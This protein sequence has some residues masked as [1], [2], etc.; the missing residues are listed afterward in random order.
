MTLPR[1]ALAAV[2]WAV[3]PVLAYAQGEP[4]LP[5]PG[6]AASLGWGLLNMGG[7]GVFA[8]VVWQE[9][10]SMRLQAAADRQAYLE[11]VRGFA[12]AAR[13]NGEALAVLRDRLERRG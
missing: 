1:V 4:V 13:A 2:L 8:F 7:L 9:L 11:A 5:T 3:V 12:D 10:R 6:D